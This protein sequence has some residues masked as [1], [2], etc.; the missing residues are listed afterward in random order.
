[1][2]NPSGFIFGSYEYLTYFIKPD[3]TVFSGEA[4]MF[5]NYEFHMF[6]KDPTKLAL[7]KY[8]SACFVEYETDPKITFNEDSKTCYF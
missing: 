6:P 2:F 8:D 4:E 7:I 3:L 1:M 5:S